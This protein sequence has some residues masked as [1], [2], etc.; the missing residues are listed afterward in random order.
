MNKRIKVV[1]A[2]AAVL[3]AAVIVALAWRPVGRTD[4]PARVAAPP[5]VTSPQQVVETEV[6]S[7][8]VKARVARAPAGKAPEVASEWRQFLTGNIY[9][10]Q[11]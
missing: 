9:A 8:Q 11:L 7:A 3:V 1:S 5:A 10:L 6:R 2:S 4:K